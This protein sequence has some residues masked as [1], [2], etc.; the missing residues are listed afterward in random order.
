M[1]RFLLKGILNDR[2]R[3]L[4]PLLVVALGV[5]L[6]VLLHAWLTGVMGESIA[7]NANFNTGHLKVTT[8]AYAE[9]EALAPNDLAMLNA[10]SLIG[11]LR[12][13]FP[14]TEWV[15]RIRFGGLADFPNA[16]GETRA[17][18]T[19]AG[20]G[21]DLFS[22]NPSEAARMNIVAALASGRLPQRQGEALI[23][24][25]FAQKVKAGLG[26]TFTFFGTTM[27]GAMALKNFTIVGTL[28]FGTAALDRGALIVD[29]SDAQNALAMELASGE[30]LGFFRDGQSHTDEA[31][32]IARSFNAPFVHSPDPYAPLMRAM[33][34]QGTMAEI[35]DYSAT[36]GS[37]LVTV[38]VLC[39]SIVLWNTGLLGGLRRYSEF[40]VRLAMGEEKRHIYAT[41]LAEAAIIGIIGSV[42]GTMVGLAI[43]Y[44]LQTEGLDIGQS[45]QN[46]SLMMPSTVRAVITPT[47]FYIGFVPGLLSMVMGNA[48]AGMGIY[49]RQTA[50]LF[51]ELEV[52]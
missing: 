7:L 2:S 31:S 34:E 29:I 15:P 42:A 40:G 44:Y 1:I 12:A 36:L 22:G 16:E 11:V 47:A 24:H 39:M 10:D 13:Q 46:S 35:V 38:F 26:D 8:R 32:S 33:R 43:G 9:D 14:Q 18:G 19:V 48:L 51:K 3:S 17:Q 25:D 23:A 52:S 6:T 21:I 20:W 49:K 50:M 37:I 5:A 4:L 28:R 41:L 27:E 45:L 30:I